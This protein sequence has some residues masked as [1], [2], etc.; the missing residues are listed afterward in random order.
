MGRT[1]KLEIVTPERTIIEENVSSLV[2]PGSEGYL[3]I[4]GNHLPLVASLGTGLLKYKQ[5]GQEH[6][7]ALS[8]GFMEVSGN[9]VTI[10]AET[11]ERPDEIDA[12]RAKAA[13][14]RARKRLKEHRPGLDVA[15]AELALR[16]ARNRLKA[17][18]RNP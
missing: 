5:E 11:V 12:E 14:A 8:R 6:Y 1:M 16:R 2:A 15:R 9:K 10:F 4:M 13:E 3:G 18:K 17:R 7:L